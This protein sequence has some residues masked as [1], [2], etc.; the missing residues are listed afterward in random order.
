MRI[1]AQNNRRRIIEVARTAFAVDGLGVPIREIARLAGVAPATIYRHFATHA[2]LIHA[3]LAD[4]VSAC[5]EELR[6]ALE[7]PDHGRALRMTIENFA[8]RQMRERGLNEALLGPAGSRGPFATERLAHAKA[9]EELVN[10]ARGSGAI[11]AGLTAD[12]VRSGLIAI[13]SIGGLPPAAA[14]KTIRRLVTLIFT[15]L[16]A[17]AGSIAVRE[18]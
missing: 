6:C 18:N 3:V 14:R 16:G 1:D 7:D 10:R 5:Q 4:H 11:D 15:G 2:D 13:A 8:Q 9:F 17:P 12:D